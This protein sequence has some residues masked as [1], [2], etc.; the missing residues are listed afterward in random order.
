MMTLPNSLIR[1][2]VER[3]ESLLFSTTSKES[4]YACNSTARTITLIPKDD[5]IHIKEFFASY[6]HSKIWNDVYR[7]IKHIHNHTDYDTEDSYTIARS[8]IRSAAIEGHDVKVCPKCGFVNMTGRHSEMQGAV[9]P[10]CSSLAK[11]YSPS[12]FEKLINSNN[13]A[14]ETIRLSKYNDVAYK[15][16]MSLMSYANEGKV[17]LLIA[18]NRLMF[19]F[20]SIHFNRPHGHRF[21]RIA[22]INLLRQMTGFSHVSETCFG[23][24]IINEMSDD[25][26]TGLCTFIELYGKTLT[27]SP[28]D[29]IFIGTEEAVNELRIEYVRERIGSG[30]N[31]LVNL[32]FEDTSD[33][34]VMEISRAIVNSLPL[35]QITNEA[36]V[37]TTGRINIEELVGFSPN[38]IRIEIR[39]ITNGND[40]LFDIVNSALREEYRIDV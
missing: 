37:T 19:H 13:T 17:K 16:L 22:N 39:R 31:D 8:Y 27:S 10:S 25:N 23:M 14:Y 5:R 29:F 2:N 26:W 12:A 3:D 32:L 11:K 15:K 24:G 21:R 9:C 34:V 35:G 38:E 18:N 4:V 33:E 40:R 6:E 20:P 1:F 30:S 7:I 36:T 28:D